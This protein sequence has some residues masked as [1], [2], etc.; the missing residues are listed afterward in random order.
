MGRQA[1]YRQKIVTQA[2]SVEAKTLHTY[3]VGEIRARRELAP[4]EA[5]LVAEDA[6]EYLAHLLDRGLGQID[7]PAVRG[8][9]AHRRC[10]RRDQ[11]EQMVTLTVIAD[12]DAEVLEEFG[13]VAMQVGRMARCV[14]EAYC[15][16]CLLDW[17]RL[18]VLFPFNHQALRQRLEP[19]WEM[20][21][22]LPVAGTSKDT[23][24][25]MRTLRPALAVELYLRGEDLSSV[26][27]KLCCSRTAWRRW[28]QLFCQVGGCGGEDPEATARKLGQPVALVKSFAE[29]WEEVRGD[30]R[31]AER[32]R[33]EGLWALPVPSGG[34]PRQAFRQVLLE[35]HR[36]TPAAAD[37][38]EQELR[39]LAR[40]LS[41]RG[42]SPGQIV[43]MGVAQD[44]PPGRSLG[45][46]RMVSAVLDYLV[47]EDWSLVHRDRSEELKWARLSRFAT[48]AYYQGACLSQPDLA[49]L[50]GI[51]VEAVRS[52][53]ER[54]PK[55]ILP[56]RGRL[57]DMGPTLSHA[58]KIVGL[59]MQ[60]YTETEVVRRTGHSL[61]SV[62]RYI[63]DFA[64]VSYLL[65]R[66]MPA[67]AIRTV[68]GCS[69][70]LVD[71][72]IGLYEVWSRKSGWRLGRIRLLAQAHLPPDLKKNGI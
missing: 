50:L 32:V 2:R 27:R 6:R 41:G 16:G 43:W 19:L 66:G 20:G 65:E 47:P 23:R 39:E 36:Y 8:L 40:R 62:E 25:K 54:H 38:F 13:V 42:R 44:Q 33:R 7:F 45:D 21:A 56:T 10:S 30:S 9:G 57:A 59:Y 55:V 53:M 34:T 46:C 5:A 69:M 70:R 18:G 63:L 31:L 4:E 67:T 17:P 3:L 48:G 37:Q 72:Y 58:E 49:F 64:R 68:L 71:N 14:E 11:P 60:G 52:A 29:L 22:L 1:F 28:W 24:Q 51:S 61:E 12:E 15:R 35:R 26:R